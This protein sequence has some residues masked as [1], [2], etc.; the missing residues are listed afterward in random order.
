MFTVTTVP[1]WLADTSYSG[2]TYNSEDPPGNMA[3]Y[4]KVIYDGLVYWK[5]HY[6]KF[7]YLE[8]W[9]EPDGN[10]SGKVN[11]PLSKY[12][13]I[14]AA[15]AA[16]V[17]SVNKLGLPGGAIKI[18]GPCAYYFDDAYITGLMDYAKANNLPMDFV[19]WHEYGNSATP[20]GLQSDVQQVHSWLTSRGMTA[21]TVVTEWGVNGNYV[22][23]TAAN[24]SQAAAFAAVGGYYFSLANVTHD[25]YF[26]QLQ[27]SVPAS[28]MLDYNAGDGVADPSYY[29]MK[30]M[31]MQKSQLVSTSSNGL[32][33]NGTGVGAQAT[34]D[35]TG[36][37]ILAWDYLGNGQ[38]VNINVK[39]LPAIFSGKS[40]HVQQF[41]VDDAHS[42]YLYNGDKTLDKV[43]DFTASPGSSF[44]Q[45]VA[46]GTNA[47]TLFVL[48]P[49]QSVAAVSPPTKLT[50][51]VN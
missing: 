20:S 29:T 45:T 47:V 18:G 14:Y 21:E 35:G 15:F 13:S 6:P 7:Q 30:M 32:N 16:T 28:S 19:S 4:Q 23:S 33:S 34:A 38:N 37:S 46:L 22:A 44:S 41:L 11:L 27:N 25:F 1:S 49:S 10:W 2:G 48:T 24:D 39:N 26:G 50:A 8:V 5:T 42:N 12:E 17:A 36:V 3:A 40:I 43:A 31:S 9:N 51:T